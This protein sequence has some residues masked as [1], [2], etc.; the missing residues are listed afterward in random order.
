MQKL[1]VQK[2]GGMCLATAD[3]V[4]AVATKVAERHRQ[5]H[6]MMIIVS[7]MGK[8]TD[9]LVRL[10]YSVSPEPNRRELDMLLTTG[11]RVSMSLLSMALTDLGCNAISF[12]GSQAGVLTDGSHS[13]AKIVDVRPTRLTQEL[14]NG[15]IVVLAGFQGVNPH[16]KEITTLGR[17]GSDTTAV[18]MAATFKAEACEII[19]EVHGLC[20]ADPSHIKDAHCYNEMNH[21][22]LLDMCFWGAKILHYRSVELASKLNVPLSIRFSQD[23]SKGTLVRQ[24]VD[25]FEQ[26]KVLAI[27]SHREV[28]HLE[29]PDAKDM[30]EGWSRVEKLLNQHRLAWPQILAATMENQTLR[31]M[32]TSD[33]EHLMSLS[34]VLSGGK[35]V[36][37][38]GKPMCSLTLTCHGAVASDLGPKVVAALTDAKIEVAKLLQSPLSLTI[39]VDH[40]KRERATE[41]LHSTFISG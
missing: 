27:N 33:S 39:L 28:H 20:S 32:Y 35:D 40:A 30:S 22:E 26:Q 7:A 1:I 18:A 37:P 13:N 19:K 21:A 12:T 34:R 9:E 38:F 2:Y 36:R 41:I 31:A 24:G 4:K 17:G 11:E 14:E 10:A 16:T 5:G 8:T 3:K 29:V 6:S 25:M 23:H 15:K